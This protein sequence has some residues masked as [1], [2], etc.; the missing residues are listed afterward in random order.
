MSE[1]ASAT[2]RPVIIAVAITGSVPRKRDNPAVPGTPAEQIE[3]T[4]QAYEAGAALVHSH[5]RNDDASPSSDPQRFAEAQ[6]GTATHS[7]DMIVQVSTRGG[8]RDH[9]PRGTP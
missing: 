2:M 3:S 5:V 6:A 7:P 4:Q 1:K 8:G 9:T